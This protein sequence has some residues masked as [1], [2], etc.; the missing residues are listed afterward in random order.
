MSGQLLGVQIDAVYHTALVFGGVEYLFGAGVQTVYPGS[1]H[2]GKPMEIISMGRTEVPMELI[3]EYLDSLKK[4]YTAEASILC[5]PASGLIQYFNL[6]DISLTICSS[7]IA[8]IF[9]TILPCS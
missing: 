4:V 3:L 9:L 5:E 2:Y 6:V 8:T 1:S 7:T